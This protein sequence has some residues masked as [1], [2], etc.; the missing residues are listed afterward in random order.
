M[1]KFEDPN[2]LIL[3]TLGCGLIQEL[4]SKQPLQPFSPD[5]VDFLDALS[6]HLLTHK[7]IREFA[8]IAA[9]AFFCRRKNLEAWK[10]RLRMENEMRFGRGLAYH[11]T[12]SNIPLNFAF[13]F[14]LGFLSGNTN[15]VRVPS[16]KF[17]QVAIIIESLRK[18]EIEL[19]VSPL[20]GR[21]YFVSFDKE[22]SLGEYLTKHCDV[23]V[24]WGGD[25]TINN[26]RNTAIS[27]HAVDVVFPD[28]YSLCLIDAGAVLETSNISRLASNFFNDTYLFDQLAC[29]SP[30]LVIWFGDD[31]SVERAKAKFWAAVQDIVHKIYTTHI[32]TG[33]NKFTNFCVQSLQE[34]VSLESTRF[35]NHDNSVWRV[36][37][38][39]DPRN[40]EDFRVGGGYFV[41]HKIQ[42]LEMLSKFIN[43][44]TQTLSYY[45]FPKSIL[46]CALTSVGAFGINRV[47][48]VGRSMEFSLIWD[49]H[50]LIRSLSRR[51]EVS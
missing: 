4:R 25:T 44:K 22:D 17:E 32:I 45:G 13:S 41:E 16:A 7:R 42:T 38:E 11:I 20:V 21:S 30:H 34:E 35:I 39:S 8:D 23:R 19:P 50:D 29:S 15:V 46:E 40:L 2:C 5:L 51:V 33:V 28:R 1:F 24:I 12:P 49:G 3:D 9:F 26:I 18:A 48:P 43:R 10:Y 31:N 37:M 47:V 36:R 6:K 14:L 27:S